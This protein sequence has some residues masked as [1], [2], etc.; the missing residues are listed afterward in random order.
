LSKKEGNGV[1][2]D[3]TETARISEH[4]AVKEARDEGLL[5]PHGT[6]PN[7]KQDRIF[8]IL[9]KNPNG[10]NNQITGNRKLEKAIDIKD[11]LD[12]DG[13]L[14]FKHRLNLRHRDNKNNFKQ[15]FQQE[16]A[17]RAVA[18]N[19]VHQ[20]IGRVQEGRTGMVLFGNSTGF[21]TKTGKDPYDLGQWCWTLYEGSKGHCTRVVVAYNACNNS[22]KDS[23]TTYQQQRQY[24][25]MSKKDL[26]C[27]NKLFQKHL[28]HQLKQWHHGRDRIVLFMDHNEHTYDGPLGRVLSDPGGLALQEAVLKHTGK[29]MCATFFQGGKPINGLWV[30]SDIE[31]A[32]ACVMPFGYGIGDHQMFILDITLE[33]LVRRNP[34]KV[35]RPASWR[36]ISKVPSCGEVYVQSLERNII[37]HRLL[38]RLNKVHHSNLPREKKRRN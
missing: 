1:S 30:T 28:V 32:N 36:L 25:I 7:L 24:F 23:Q 19:N 14:F 20:N 33:S 38:E 22:K 18:T 17:C 13:L 12:V 37:Q 10:L 29:R 27:P 26:T 9:C 4:E 21:I 15:M 8:R 3:G 11:D 34:T 6:P 5:Q 31:I 2:E 35:V 16:V